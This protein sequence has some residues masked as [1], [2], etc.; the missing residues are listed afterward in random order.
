MKMNNEHLQYVLDH[1][2]T[3]QYTLDSHT[4]WLNDKEGGFQA[5]LRDEDLRH[6]DF[7]GAILTEAILENADLRGANFKGADL[8]F[9][10]LTFA[11][12][13][14]ANFEG[15]DLTGA[16]LSWSDITG[17]NFKGATLDRAVTDYLTNKGEC[18]SVIEG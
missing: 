14:G 11:D 12:L 3:L 8:S 15:A 6:A 9:A 17:A 2:Q 7:S 13:R 5:I 10:D 18:V 16:N 1:Q 4:L